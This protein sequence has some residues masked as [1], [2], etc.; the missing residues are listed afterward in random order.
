M[1]AVSIKTSRRNT[2]QVQLCAA[3]RTHYNRLRARS[4]LFP[5]LPCG[6]GPVVD[7]ML[8][9][10]YLNGRH[11]RRGNYCEYLPQI[12]RRG[13]VEGVAGG[14]LGSSTSY[15]LA[16]IECFHILRVDGEEIVLVQITNLPVLSWIRS[17]RVVHR[18]AVPTVKGWDVL[19][20]TLQAVPD[21]VNIVHVDSITHKVFLAPHFT[22]ANLMCALRIWEAR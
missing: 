5:A 14:R 21:D 17:L 9:G 18:P 7:A 10:I 13:N 4:A 15:L 16:R 12:H 20:H 19:Y 3:V 8:A 1:F 6:G 2:K 11:Y 22:D